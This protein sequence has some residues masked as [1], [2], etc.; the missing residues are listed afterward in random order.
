MP[1]RGTPTRN[2]LDRIAN[3]CCLLKNGV[4]IEDTHYKFDL[5]QDS[6][7]RENRGESIS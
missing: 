7:C 4:Q 1:P 3:Q 2:V 5:P 6:I